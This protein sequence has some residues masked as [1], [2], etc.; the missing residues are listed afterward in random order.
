MFATLSGDHADNTNSDPGLAETR[1]CSVWRAESVEV[2]HPLLPADLVDS[3]RFWTDKAYT[4][5]RNK[6][7][8]QTFR[9]YSGSPTGT[10]KMQIHSSP[11]CRRIFMRRHVLRHRRLTK[12]N[13]S[14]L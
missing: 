10:L 1:F 8:F 13:T 14:L 6:E 7:Q 12:L 3:G 5:L 11:K 2:K 4:E 9:V